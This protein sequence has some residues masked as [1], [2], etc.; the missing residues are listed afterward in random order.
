MIIALESRNELTLY[1]EKEFENFADKIIYITA[2]G[3]KG[4]KGRIS[5]IETII[6]E[7]KPI[8]QCFFIGCKH[9]MMEAYNT[10][11]RMGNIPTLVSMN[12]IM[13]DGTGMCGGCRLSL[14]ENGKEITKFACV[15]GPIFDGHLINWE[16]L[17]TRLEQFNEPEI[18]VYQ[19]HSCKAIERFMTGEMDE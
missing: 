13:I 1:L 5:T 16:E 18:E 2:D 11:K 10:T 17:M 7:N 6:N 14:I 4:I 8:D 15:D 3:S 9:M 19:N 12:T